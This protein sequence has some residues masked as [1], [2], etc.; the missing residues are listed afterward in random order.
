[1][2]FYTEMINLRDLKLQIRAFKNKN[3]IKQFLKFNQMKIKGLS[4]KNECK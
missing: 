1:M 3:L 4:E 2:I